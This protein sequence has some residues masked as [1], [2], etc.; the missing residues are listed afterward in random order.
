MGCIQGCGVTPRLVVPEAFVPSADAPE[1]WNEQRLCLQRSALT[2]SSGRVGVESLHTPANGLICPHLRQA[3]KS[4]LQCRW[5]RLAAEQVLGE[6]LVKQSRVL[7]I[8]HAN[9]DSGQ[10]ADMD[11]IGNGR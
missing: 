7:F 10:G 9:D 4:H 3:K 8:R 2:F 1:W 5:L 6:L 11:A